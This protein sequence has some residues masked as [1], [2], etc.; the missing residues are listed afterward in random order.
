MPKVR[1]GFAGS[2][3]V[4]S[5]GTGISIN[6]PK[7][8][9]A[10]NVTKKPFESV[11]FSDELTIANAAN[12][13]TTSVT[14][15]AKALIT[16]VG[17][18]CT[19]Q[20]THTAAAGGTVTVDFGT[21]AGGQQFVANAIIAAANE[22]ILA[23]RSISVLPGNKITSGGAALGDF[24]QA[25]PLFASASRAVHVQVTT[26][27]ALSGTSTGGVRMFVKYTIVE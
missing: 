6:N 16:D 7:L 3:A 26:T 1:L 2:G 13:F 25:A 17:I 22:T 14:L 24:V 20:I 18:V 10:I 27:Q 8:G 19:T 4:N 5:K 15:P 12:D 23:G 21:A 9:G 11:K